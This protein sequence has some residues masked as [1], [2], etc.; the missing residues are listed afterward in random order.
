MSCGISGMSGMSGTVALDLAHGSRP[1]PENL[2]HWKHSIHTAKSRAK[3]INDAAHAA[4]A[5]LGQV[6]RPV[7]ARAATAVVRRR[8]R[9]ARLRPTLAR[10]PGNGGKP[11]YINALGSRFFLETVR[12]AAARRANVVVFQRCFFDFF[13]FR[14][15]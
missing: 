10:T 11:R 12:G 8:R 2:S 7:M 6:G 4:H 14:F 1:G 5:A 3:D 13:R 9:A 15:H